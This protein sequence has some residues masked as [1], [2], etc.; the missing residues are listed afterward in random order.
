MGDRKIILAVDGSEQADYAF[1]WYL[2]NVNRPGDHVVLTH[3]AEYNIKFGLMGGSQSDLEQISKQAKDENERVENMMGNYLDKLRQKSIKA[4][5][6][7]VT[8]KKPGE[9]VVEQAVKENAAMIIMG[10][11]GLGKLRKTLLGS[12]SEYVVG[13]APPQCAV[14]VLRTK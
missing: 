2:N 12:V 1:D 9:A 6:V 11:R 7:C 10:C 3:A 4:T 8:G 14:T 13:H 5:N